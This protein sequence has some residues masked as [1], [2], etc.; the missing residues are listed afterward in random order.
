LLEHTAGFLDLTKPEFDHSDPK[1]LTLRE[2][3]AVKP[4]ARIGRWP[5]GMHSSYSNAGAGLAA[6][7]L[8]DVTGERYEDFVERH[9]FKRLAMSTASYFLDY[10]TEAKL[11]TGFDSDGRTVIPYWHMIMRPFGGI[12]ATPRDMAALMQLLINKGQ[13]QGKR[14]LRTSSIERM[15]IPTTTLPLKMA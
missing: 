6:Y 15:E 4:E 3:L 9:L 7:V 11:A 14:I 10:A 8:E 13:F 12:N 2:G 5:P 1:P